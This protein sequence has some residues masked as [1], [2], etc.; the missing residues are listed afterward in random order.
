[1]DEIKRDLVYEKI[2]HKKIYSYFSFLNKVNYSN[3]LPIRNF[4]LS[5]KFNNTKIKVYVGNGNNKFLL[6]AL[7]KRRFWLEIT[8]KIT[9]DTKFIWTQNSIKEI[10]KNQK[11]YNQFLVDQAEREGK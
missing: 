4:A 2:Y 3:N 6:I 7:L 1:M 8:N 5:E 10:H 11:S 9:S